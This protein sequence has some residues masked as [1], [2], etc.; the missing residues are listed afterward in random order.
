MA[1]LL[2]EEFGDVLAVLVLVDDDVLRCGDE[3][4]LDA[5][6]ETQKILINDH[7]Y[8]IRGNNVYTIDG[9]LVK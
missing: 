3:A 1:L 2:G 5:Q 6:G 4:V 9:Q 7:V 8:I